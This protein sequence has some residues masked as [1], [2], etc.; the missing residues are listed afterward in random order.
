M[1]SAR[2][3]RSSVL[4]KRSHQHNQCPSTTPSFDH[5]PM[6]DP[7]SK[8]SRTS[9]CV[10]D[11]D[12]NK[13]NVPP[14]HIDTHIVNPSRTRSTR[15]PSPALETPMRHKPCKPPLAVLSP[16]S[17]S[18][19]LYIAARRHAS[20][21]SILSQSSSEMPTT[22]TTSPLLLTPALPIHAHARAILPQHAMAHSRLRK[23][24]LLL[25]TK[26]P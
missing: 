18:S 22:T 24:A 19:T 12:G 5:L 17:A 26:S 23:F 1:S 15:H 7:T 16:I 3:T 2:I 25:T 21:P 6:P 14:L 10:L 11:H 9:L 8:R 20:S 4:G 13:E